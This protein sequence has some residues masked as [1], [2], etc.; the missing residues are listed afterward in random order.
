MEHYFCEFCGKKLEARFVFSHFDKRNGG[1]LYNKLFICPARR[2]WNAFLHD[3][4]L[5]LAGSYGT[6]PQYYIE[7]YIHLDKENSL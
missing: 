2:W 4:R 3:A 5:V 7:D 6:S 1:K